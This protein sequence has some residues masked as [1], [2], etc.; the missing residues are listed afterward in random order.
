MS[1][2]NL[3]A[4]TLRVTDQETARVVAVHDAAGRI[5]G[6]GCLVTAKTIVTCKH[7]VT[8]A[9]GQ[10]KLGSKGLAKPIAITLIGVGTG[11]RCVAE[12]VSYA[13]G[14]EPEDDL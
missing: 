3:K 4:L 9:L 14:D 8:Y 12:V 6:A 11:T 5:V 10:K 7:V 2:D 1:E 13:D